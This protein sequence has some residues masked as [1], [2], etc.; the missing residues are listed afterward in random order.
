MKKFVISSIGC[1]LTLISG[2]VNAQPKNVEELDFGNAT[3][4]QDIR[5]IVNRLAKH[6]DLGNQPI[7]FTITPGSYAMSVASGMGL[8]KDESCDY[9]CVWDYRITYLS[10]FRKGGIRMYRNIGWY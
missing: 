4:Y 2:A 7:I 6:N 9:G 1:I 8:C 3:E 10:R 5:E